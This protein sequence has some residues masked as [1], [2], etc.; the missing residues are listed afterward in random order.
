M[1]KRIRKKGQVSGGK[2]EK[3]YMCKRPKRK[4]F[5]KREGCM[6]TGAKC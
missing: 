1:K 3:G 6:I 4:A 2:K 5:Q